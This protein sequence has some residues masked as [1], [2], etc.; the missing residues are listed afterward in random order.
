MPSPRWPLFDAVRLGCFLAGL[1]PLARLLW[2]AMHE[3]LSANPVEFVTRSTGTWAL[4]FLCLSLAIT[5]LRRLSGEA[6]WMKLRRQLGLYS[7]FYAL[8]HVSLWFWVEHVFAVDAMWRDVLRRPFIAAG[9]VA[10]VLLLPLAATSSQAAIR[11]LG[12]HWR[13]LHRAVYLIALA[14][15]LHYWWGKAGKNDFAPVWPYLLAVGALLGIR[16]WWALA[17]RWKAHRA[18]LSGVPEGAGRAPLNRDVT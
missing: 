17:D 13:R 4:V 2:L 14:S 8:L 1:L 6:R 5:P 3:G 7:F 9:F 15:L 18:A 10:F 12:R 11:L 16:L